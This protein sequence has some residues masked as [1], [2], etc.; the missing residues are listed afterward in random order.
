[1]QSLL[2]WNHWDTIMYVQSQWSF[3]EILTQCFPQV[4]CLFLSFIVPA[5]WGEQNTNSSGKDCRCNTRSTP[6]PFRCTF[7][8][9]VWDQ[10]VRTEH[11]N[12]DVIMATGRWN[13]KGLICHRF[14][15]E[16]CSTFERILQP[17]TCSI[18]ESSQ[19]LNVPWLFYV[20]NVWPT[21]AWWNVK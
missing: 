4:L 15:W 2:C 8:H 18:F 3:S 1:M 14:N 11:S 10:N 16:F 12:D 5:G 7:S 19:G 9:T 21:V 13:L 6:T 20:C 17:K